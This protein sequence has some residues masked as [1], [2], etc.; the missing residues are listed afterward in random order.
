[1]LV[2]ISIPHAEH[3]KTTRNYWLRVSGNQHRCEE[4]LRA[5][6]TDNGRTCRDTLGRFPDL[7][8]VEARAKRS[9]TSQDR[10]AKTRTSP[11][12]RWRACTRPQAATTGTTPPT[13]S[14]PCSEPCLP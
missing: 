4:Q 7:S 6:R 5:G 12:T 1:M 14:S 13:H 2:S 9:S 10:A 11:A 3:L 8:V